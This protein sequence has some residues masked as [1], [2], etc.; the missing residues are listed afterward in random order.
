MSPYLEQVELT[1]PNSTPEDN[2]L[3]IVSPKSL[4]TRRLVENEH[5]DACHLEHDPLSGYLSQHFGESYNF[6]SGNIEPL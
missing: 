6:S 2:P 1:W 3:I 4:F 5:I